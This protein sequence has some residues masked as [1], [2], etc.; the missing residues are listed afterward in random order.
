MRL[1]ARNAIEVDPSFNRREAER[2]G[3]AYLERG[4]ESG[5]A[6]EEGNPEGMFGLSGTMTRQRIP[7]HNVVGSRPRAL[8]YRDQLHLL[9]W[10]YLTSS[11][12][13]SSAGEFSGHSLSALNSMT[14]IAV[15]KHLYRSA[16]MFPPSAKRACSPALGLRSKLMIAA[17]ERRNSSF[18]KVQ[19]PGFLRAATYLQA[20]LS[21]SLD[22]VGMS[23][24]GIWVKNV[25]WTGK[26][27]H[28]LCSTG[29]LRD[30]TTPTP[31]EVAELREVRTESKRNRIEFRGAPAKQ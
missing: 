26:K 22:S 14:E 2:E 20:A 29:W 21:K 12:E 23:L 27:R 30:G 15:F 28:S 4:A 9:P 24:R 8:R 31:Q 6:L 7:T 18:K 25:W 19:S 1:K 13:P 3:R 11:A 10:H 5:T 17:Q 16:A